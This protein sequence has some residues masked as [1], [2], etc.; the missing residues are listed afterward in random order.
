MYKKMRE[1]MR[2]IYRRL[3]PFSGE[4]LS[5]QEIRHLLRRK[6]PVIFEI[7]CADGRDT[8]ELIAALG[9]KDFRMFCFE[10]DPRNIRSFRNNVKDPRAELIEAAVGNKVGTALFHQTSTIY[11]SSLKKPNYTLLNEL[12]P[13]IS[14]GAE[15]EVPV[16]TIDSFMRERGLEFV[17]FIW[18]DVQGAEDLMIEG[19][20]QSIS[21]NK[22]LYIYTE[23]SEKRFYENEPNYGDIINSLEKK[24]QV[25]KK[26]RSDVLLRN[27]EINDLV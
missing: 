1:A 11:S 4:S 21:G 27:R 15:I 16:T 13:E 8:A 2:R 26:Y 23:Y 20:A 14:P 3:R 6:C 10:P 19:A 5:K 22:I 17:D 18:A 9:E 12:W 7:G 24:W 25:V